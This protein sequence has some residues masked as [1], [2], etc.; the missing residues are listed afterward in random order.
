MIILLRCL[1]QAVDTWLRNLYHT[2]SCSV[3]TENGITNFFPIET[4]VRQGCVLSSVLF[5]LVLNFVLCQSVNQQRNGLPLGQM[6]QLTDLD[7]VDDIA[8]LASTQPGLANMTTALER[9]STKI[10]L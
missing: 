1:H 7:F 3:L 8:L 5:L 10:G 4:W 2:S 9:E 6:E